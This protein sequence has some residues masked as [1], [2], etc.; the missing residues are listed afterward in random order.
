MIKYKCLSCNKS[1]SNKN[2]EKFKKWFKNTFKLSDNDINK[3]IFLLGKGDYP[4]KYMDDRKFNEKLLPKIEDFYSDFTMD[5]MKDSD[6]NHTKMFCKN[7]EIKR[8]GECHDLHIN[9]I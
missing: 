5:D 2:D 3:F 4:D 8:L 7:F 1:Y 9:P 6:Y